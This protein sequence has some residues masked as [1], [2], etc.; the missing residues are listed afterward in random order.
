MPPVDVSH[1]QSPAMSETFYDVLGV[2]ADASPAAIDAAYREQLKQVHP[3]VS[4]DADA[5]ERTRRLI[6][7]RDVLLDEDERARYDRVG[8]DTYVERGRASDRSDVA[9]AARRAGYGAESPTQRSATRQRDP[10][11]ARERAQ[12]RRDRER[13]ARERVRSDRREEPFSGEAE[14]ATSG[15]SATGTA[16]NATTGDSDSRAGG[17]D[18]ASSGAGGWDVGGVGPTWQFGRAAGRR[19]PSRRQRVDWALDGRELT[20][21]GIGFPLFPVLLFTA[22]L[23]A[24]PLPVNVLIGGCVV[25]FVGYMQS[26]PRVALLVFGPWSLLTPLVLSTLQVPFLSVLGVL[27]LCSTWLPFGFTVLTVAVMRR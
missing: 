10:H 13:R 17:R 21:L 24:F 26:L 14:R 9:Q 27:A 5:R 7:A 20:V 4:D 2:D 18:R 23:P 8:H 6:A 1:H 22:L 12:G 15:E 11:A 3:D 16:A 25:A 19:R